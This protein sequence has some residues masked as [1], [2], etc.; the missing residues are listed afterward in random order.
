[1]IQFQNKV[2]FS[3]VLGLWKFLCSWSFFGSLRPP[4]VQPFSH[5]TLNSPQTFRGESD[6]RHRWEGWLFCY[7]VTWIWRGSA[8]AHRFHTSPFHPP[9]LPWLFCCYCDVK[10]R[11]W[12][13]HV[14]ESI[15]FNQMITGFLSIFQRAFSSSSCAFAEILFS[16]SQLKLPQPVSSQQLQ[17]LQPAEL[18]TGQPVHQRLQVRTLNVRRVEH[19]SH[20]HQKLTSQIQLQKNQ[21]KNK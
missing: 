14:C 2:Y 16:S 20:T 19:L 21:Y 8:H 12:K 13:A 11:I 15:N 6:L 4:A 3:V 17:R 9:H 7:P 1:M 5:S 18:R 10:A